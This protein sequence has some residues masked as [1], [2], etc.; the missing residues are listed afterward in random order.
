MADLKR[1]LEDTVVE[2]DLVEE[3]RNALNEAHESLYEARTR[4]DYNCWIAAR[5]HRSLLPA[6]V[7]HPQIDIDIRHLPVECLGGDYCQVRFPR[8]SVGYVTLCHVNGPGTAAALLATRISSEVRHF[9]LDELAPGEVV[10]SLNEFVYEHF[11]DL[12]M[13]VTFMVARIDLAQSR[14]TYSGA[15]HPGAMILRPGM[16][17][18]HRLASQNSSIG[19]NK[20]MLSRTPEHTLPLAAGDRFLFFTEGV[21]RTVDASNRQLGQSG[22]ARFATRAMTRQL[23]D[24]ADAILEQVARYRYGPARDDRTIVVAEIK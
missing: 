10:R 5:V 16:G 14:I 20:R 15:G 19:A 18:V 24:M 17:V 6:A 4:L 21:T 12:R 13:G 11:H 8:P 23:F 22:L 7:S 3:L 1:T 2:V 9:I